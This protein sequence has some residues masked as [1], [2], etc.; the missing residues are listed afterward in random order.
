[1]VV[2]ISSLWREAWYTFQWEGG[3]MRM[4]V[5]GKIMILWLSQVNILVVWIWNNSIYLQKENQ[6]I[7]RQWQY[8]AQEEPVR[9]GPVWW[10]FTRSLISP[11]Q[12]DLYGR[13]QS[14]RTDTCSTMVITLL[15]RST[16]S[17]C[18]GNHRCTHP[19]PTLTYL[20]VIYRGRTSICPLWLY[21]AIQVCLSGWY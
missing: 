11:T 17:I 19:P 13:V 10:V 15:T 7:L 6:L 18:H 16:K 2:P 1:M 4:L 8:P 12:A 21:S 5:S 14:E 3:S 20:A 9:D